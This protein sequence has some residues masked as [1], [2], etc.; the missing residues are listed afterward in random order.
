[1]FVDL[2]GH[3]QPAPQSASSSWRG[4]RAKRGFSEG[5]DRRGLVAI[6]PVDLR[7]GVDSL[8]QLSRERLG[9]GCLFVFRDWRATAIK[10]LAFEGR[11]L[12]VA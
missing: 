7:K 6:E 9:T 11:R 8:A 1:M 2:L 4:P 12:W 10:L 5:R 3:C